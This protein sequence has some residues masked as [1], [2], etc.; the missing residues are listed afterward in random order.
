MVDPILNGMYHAKS[1]SRFA[2]IN[3]LCVQN[4][5]LSYLIR[6]ESQSATQVQYSGHDFKWN[7]GHQRKRIILCGLIRLRNYYMKGKAN[8]QPKINKTSKLVTITLNL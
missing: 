6:R 8:N 7:C 1:L 4:L 3:A 2:Y 5:F